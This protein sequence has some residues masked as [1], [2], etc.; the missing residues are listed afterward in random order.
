MIGFEGRLQWR[1]HE[2]FKLR[3]KL[4]QRK[5]SWDYKRLGILSHSA[6]ERFPHAKFAIRSFLVRRTRNEHGA[7]AGVL[8]ASSVT[9]IIGFGAAPSPGF[10]RKS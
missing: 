4:P 10:I 2:L 9:A 8:Q 1:Q 3:A 7:R 5:K 6:R